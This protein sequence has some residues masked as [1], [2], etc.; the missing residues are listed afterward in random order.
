MREIIHRLKYNSERWLAKPL[1]EWMTPLREDPRLQGVTVDLLIPV[2]L[3]PLRERERGYN[4]AALLADA[5]GK[6]WQIPVAAALQRNIATETQTRFDRKQR[7]KNLRGAFRVS[8]PERIAGKTILLVD[9]VFTTGSTLDE[10][11]RT[12]LDAGSSAVWCA[13]AAR[14]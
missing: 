2:P 11:A 10:C 3:H 7:M 8:K 13:T 1:A 12:L 5:L 14:A 9:D 4:Q 6:S